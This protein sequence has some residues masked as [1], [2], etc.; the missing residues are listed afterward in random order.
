MNT[1]PILSDDL[2]ELDE[3][4]EENEDELEGFGI[5]DDENDLGESKDENAL[6]D[7]YADEE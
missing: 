5:T 2:N 1:T 3:L 4:N 7:F 6:S